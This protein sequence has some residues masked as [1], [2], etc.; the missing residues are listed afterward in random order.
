MPP[1]RGRVAAE[2]APSDIAMNNSKDRVTSVIGAIKSKKPPTNVANGSFALS[3]TATVSVP[4]SGVASRPA[5]PT[6]DSEQDH[7]HVCLLYARYPCES[8]VFKSFNLY[9]WI[10]AYLYSKQ[11]DWLTL[12][13]GSL[14]AYRSTY[15]LQIPSAYTRPH[16]ELLY[17]SCE[18]ALRAPSRVLA[19]RKAQD[20]K[21]YRKSQVQRSRDTRPNIN[22]VSKSSK[23]IRSKDKE[24]KSSRRKERV[25]A[26]A[27]SGSAP[28][29]IEA[30]PSPNSHPSQQELASADDGSKTSRTAS[31]EPNE[32]PVVTIPP[33]LNQSN[34]EAT[35]LG[36]TS[37]NILATSIRKHFNAQQLNEADTIARFS[38]VVRQQG[39]VYSSRIQPLVQRTGQLPPTTAELIANTAT[40]ATR[41]AASASSGSIPVTVIP[42]AV[43]GAGAPI[44]TASTKNST[45]IAHSLAAPR[46]LAGNHIEVEGSYGDGNGWIMGTTNC[47]RQIRMSDS[48]GGGG[49]FRLR[50]RPAPWGQE[51]VGHQTTT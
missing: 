4:S 47:G 42:A 16:A 38:Y 39:S 15:R 43:K 40:Q 36:P 33:T 45:H 12:P 18:L 32:E 37:A 46:T 29:S 5:G 34:P 19:R 13:M 3:K 51:V 27:E 26:G 35:I 50:F 44:T 22:G 10:T 8:S 41:S 21:L 2:D 48:G 14:Q 11:I 9:S 7:P 25:L 31:I 24:R 49:T 23:S 20:L 6:A 1:A 17:N 28:D 30:P